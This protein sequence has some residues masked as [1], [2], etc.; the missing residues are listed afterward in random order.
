MGDNDEDK[1]VSE[2]NEVDEKLSGIVGC[3]KGHILFHQPSDTDVN[4]SPTED[5]KIVTEEADVDKD[6]VV[7]AVLS[8]ETLLSSDEED[9]LAEIS[10][11][12]DEQR[13]ADEAEASTQI[14]MDG[15]L[16]S[17]EG[18]GDKDKTPVYSTE[19]GLLTDD[20]MTTEDKMPVTTEQE[21]A[22][23]DE[24]PDEEDDKQYQDVKLDKAIAR[25][26]TKVESMVDSIEVQLSDIEA[27]IGDKLHF[28]DKDG[29][30]ILSREEMAMCL[31][32]V[33]K[34]DLTIEE[35][36]AIAAD[37]DENKDGLFS[38]EELSKWLETNKLVQLVGEGEYAEVDKMI[39]AKATA[40]A[41]ENPDV[42]EQEESAEKKR[43]DVTQ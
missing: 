5:G 29:D 16:P 36:M 19:D 10:I 38:I 40:K 3:D 30:G 35:A 24:Q 15:E 31:Q 21:E 20:D 37:M 25:L 26:K 34:R 2:T 13:V 27:K 1:D 7:T 33:L 22:E 12:S 11:E 39:A 42:A 17:S 6:D 23:P 14:S 4:T 32:K 8:D 18:A 43:K 28:L 9:H 41:R